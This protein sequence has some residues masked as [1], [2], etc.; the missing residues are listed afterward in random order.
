MIARPS[1]AVRR[2]DQVDS[3]TGLAVVSTECLASDFQASLRRVLR[4]HTRI[5][6]GTDQVVHF[7]SP[8]I[9]GFGVVGR[10]ADMSDMLN[11]LLTT[12]HPNTTVPSAIQK[13]SL[14]SVLMR[15]LAPK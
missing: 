8:V 9:V 10:S 11:Y 14:T 4:H 1:S 13:S 3:G 6:D 15:A 7:D 2:R 12:A 5:D